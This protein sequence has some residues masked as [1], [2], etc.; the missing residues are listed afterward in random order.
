MFFW[1]RKT[2]DAAIPIVNLSKAIQHPEKQKVVYVIR[3]GESA[4]NKWRR[5]SF[6]YFRLRDMCTYDPLMYDAPLNERGEQQAVECRQRTQQFFTSGSGVCGSEQPNNI[7]RVY[8]SP[9]SRAVDTVRLLFAKSSLIATVLPC[10]TERAETT[11]DIGLTKSKF[12][13]K[14]A[15]ALVGDAVS[16][17]TVSHSETLSLSSV[18]PETAIKL[19]VSSFG[20]KEEWWYPSALHERPRWW[21]Q[22]IRR[23]PKANVDKRANEFVKH[24][25]TQPERCVAVVGHSHFFMQWTGTRKLKNLE[26]RPFLLDCSTGKLTQ[27]TD[28]NLFMQNQN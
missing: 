19:D 20:D 9:L 8:V 1:R 4:Y 21:F 13:D 28:T 12:I 7:Q 17:S 23:E 5:D 24:L 11:G 26:V 27:I 22:R 3:H 6:K 14:Y 2:S 10:L 15:H 18:S 25:C 16:P